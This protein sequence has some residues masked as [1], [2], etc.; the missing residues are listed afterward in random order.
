MRKFRVYDTVEN[1]YPDPD[2]FYLNCD[3]ILMHFINPELHILSEAG[4]RYIVEESKEAMEAKAREFL[5]LTRPNFRKAIKDKKGF[6]VAVTLEL[7]KELRSI[8][9][10]ITKF[11]KWVSDRKYLIY[12]FV[13]AGG[14]GTSILL[15]RSV[16]F[17]NKKP[18][19]PEYL[20][21]T[22]TFKE[23][24][25]KEIIGNPSDKADELPEPIKLSELVENAECDYT[26]WAIV[27]YKGCNRKIVELDLSETELNF[28]K[29]GIFENTDGD[30]VCYK[31]C[32]LTLDE[33]VAVL[34]SREVK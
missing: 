9:R 34:K 23:P 29:G 21:T 30:D 16:S 31:N 7:S 2:N 18:N 4:S 13:S 14:L 1:R 26:F 3:G 15:N 6:Y 20:P 25:P 11:W 28:R 33:A 27:D 8:E 17:S 19:L 5:G 12:E 32:F 22:D 24:I 10:E